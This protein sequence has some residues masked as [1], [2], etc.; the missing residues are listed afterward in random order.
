[1]CCEDT[2]TLD[3]PAEVIEMLA[4]YRRLLDE[5]G[6]DWGDD[7]AD[8]FRWARFSRL[9]DVFSAFAETDD[10]PAAVRRVIGDDVPAGI[11]VVSVDPHGGLTAD[12]GPSRMAIAGRTVP[13]D[14]RTAGEV[15]TVVQHPR[16]DHDRLRN[17]VLGAGAG[18]AIGGATGGKRGAIMGAIAGAVM[19]AGMGHGGVDTCAVVNPGDPLI[20]IFNRD[21]RFP[22]GP[23]FAAR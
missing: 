6:W 10:W 20:I 23:R 21:A 4:T 9:G 3:L 22:R 17:V 8:M 16:G 13:I 12:C 15:G 5:R 2:E 1:M 14:A 11:V 19:G 18:G 7:R